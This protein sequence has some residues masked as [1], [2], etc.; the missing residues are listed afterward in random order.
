METIRQL[1]VQ[2]SQFSYLELLA[3][4]GMSRHLG[5]WEATN[6]LTLACQIDNGKT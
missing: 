2:G 6:E 1:P 4:V 5:G 3:Y